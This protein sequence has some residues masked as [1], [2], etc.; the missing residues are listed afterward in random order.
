MRLFCCFCSQSYAPSVAHANVWLYDTEKLC[1][2]KHLREHILKSPVCLVMTL[3]EC[4]YIRINYGPLYIPRAHS[5]A[6][7]ELLQL[8]LISSTS[9][10]KSQICS[11]SENCRKLPPSPLTYGPRQSEMNSVSLK[12]RWYFYYRYFR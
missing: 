10:L 11:E 8:V 2:K 3:G 9:V 6:V 1:T 12:V 5:P 7:Q 4:K